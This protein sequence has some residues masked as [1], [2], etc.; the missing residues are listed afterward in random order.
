MYTFKKITKR[1]EGL[2]YPQE[3]LCVSNESFQLPLRA[4]LIGKDNLITDI[5]N[6]HAFTGY[7]PVIFALSS[8]Y[9]EGSSE[10]ITIFF[11]QDRIDETRFFSQDRIAETGTVSHNPIANTGSFL[12]KSAIAKLEL[13]KIKSIQTGDGDVRFYEGVNGEHHFTSFIAQAAGQLYNR[14][15]NNKPGNVF[16]AGNLYKQVQI[17]YS[18]PRK[19]SL[20]T[21]GKNGL[22]NLFPTDLHGQVSANYYIISLRHGGQA[23]AQVEALKKIVLSDMNA[24]AFKMVYSLGKNHM[25]PL[26]EANVFPFSAQVSNGFQLPIPKDSMSYKELQLESSFDAGI[27]RIFLFTIMNFVQVSSSLQ[28]LAHIHNTYATWRFKQGIQN[29]FLLR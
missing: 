8:T 9:Y 13:E 20:I 11:S 24:A 21:V 16:L 7:C 26:K 27:H 1:L 25:Q 15:Y 19:I 4:S 10:K 28:T 18:L 14:L 5:T 22:F 6:H 17:A 2:H 3:Y 29:S 23:C 12:P